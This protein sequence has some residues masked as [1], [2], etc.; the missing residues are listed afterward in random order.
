[1]V[2]CSIRRWLAERALVRRR[3]KHFASM[4]LAATTVQACYRRCVAMCLLSGAVRASTTLQ[5]WA[6]AHQARSVFARSVASVTKLQSFARGAAARSAYVK[7]KVAATALQATWHC[8]KM[9]VAFAKSVSAVIKIQSVIFRGCRARVQ[10]QA[11][12]TKCHTSAT[13]LQ[14]LV[15]RHVQRTAFARAKRAASLVQVTIRDF[16]ARLLFRRVQAVIVVQRCARKWKAVMMFSNARSAAVTLQAYIRCVQTKIRFKALVGASTV[17]TS[18]QRGRVIFS[19]FRAYR[20]A[21]L[22]LQTAFREKLAHRVLTQLRAD[23]AYLLTQAAAIVHGAHKIQRAFRQYLW[24]QQRSR[25]A[26]VIQRKV[27]FYAMTK[28][29][30]LIESKLLKVQAFWR[31][32]IARLHVQSNERLTEMRTRVARANTNAREDM[33]LGHRTKAALQVLLCSKNLSEVFVAIKTL[34]VS[35]RWSSTCCSWFVGEANEAVPIMYGLMRSCNRSQPHR[36]LLL[37]ALRVLSNVWPYEMAVATVAGGD[38]S[39]QRRLVPAF[40]PR[41]EI[42]VDLMQVRA[43]RFSGF[44]SR[45]LETFFVFAVHFSPA[46]AHHFFPLF[47]FDYE[48]VSRS[49]SNVPDGSSACAVA[50]LLSR[51]GNAC[52]SGQGYYEAPE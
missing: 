28:R 19:R 6:R 52:T 21:V 29:E 48:D 17:I 35:T 20:S 8:Y 50:L 16:I 38:R 49:N 23:H 3:C 40:T 15:R 13:R 30:F 11:A 4:T 43:C 1:M 9:R 45:F 41:M 22:S 10:Y 12:L 27:K 14:G 5:A 24:Q 7:K 2:Q 42:L 47:S 37:Y 51:A 44:F 26:Q 46:F 34:E 32:C 39:N 33:T 36:K 25:A 31:G 18:A